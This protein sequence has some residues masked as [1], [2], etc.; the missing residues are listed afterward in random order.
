MNGADLIKQERNRQ[1]EEERF[2]DD[3]DWRWQ[4]NELLKAAISYI[5]GSYTFWPWHEQWYK[6]KNKVRDLVRAGALIAAE[7]DRL[8]QLELANKEGEDNEP[9]RA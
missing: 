1:I 3:I 9:S 7:I 4:N 5:T 6:P 2:G 8:Q